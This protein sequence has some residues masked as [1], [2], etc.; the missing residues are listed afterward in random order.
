MSRVYTDLNI[1][2]LTG[3]KFKIGENTKPFYISGQENTQCWS[4]IQIGGSHKK[5]ILFHYH[6]APDLHQQSN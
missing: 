3:F 2:H 1:T 5:N 4:K 6:Q